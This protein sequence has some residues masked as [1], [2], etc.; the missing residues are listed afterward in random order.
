MKCYRFK[1]ICICI[2]A[3]LLSLFTLI[4][5]QD[6]KPEENKNEKEIDSMPQIWEEGFYYGPKQNEDNFQEDPI[7]MELNGKK[8]V[9]ID[10]DDP[11]WAMW[12]AQDLENIYV[13][14]NHPAVKS[15]DGV[16]YSK[17]GETLIRWPAKK[18]CNKT[19]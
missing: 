17:S 13:V 2:I 9:T 10:I 5:C 18:T 7:H 6:N 19:K 12:G 16:L 1:I 11:Y 4:A 14:E 3:M 8:E 15:V